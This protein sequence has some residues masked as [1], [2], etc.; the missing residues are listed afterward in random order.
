MHDSNKVDVT[1]VF[2]WEKCNQNKVTHN[3]D[4]STTKN[5]HQETKGDKDYYT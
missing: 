4:Q 2:Y 5:T 1:K 3:E